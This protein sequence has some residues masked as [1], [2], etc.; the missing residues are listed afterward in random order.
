MGKMD[1]LFLTTILILCLPFVF[2]TDV[3]HGGETWT[4]HFDY[5]DQLRVNVT[6]TLNIDD[7]E[8]IMPDNCAENQT[9]YY[10]CECSNNYDFNVSFKINAVN[11]YTFDF[12]YDYYKEEPTITITPSGGGSGGSSG[13]SSW[14]CGEWTECI[15][16]KTIRACWKG[17]N[18]K[19]NYTQSK[20]CV[21]ETKEQEEKEESR[22]TEM[23]VKDETEIIENITAVI[24]QNE[25]EVI[26]PTEKE[27]GWT[28]F[29][30]IIITIAF[31]AFGFY[32]IKYKR[33]SNLNP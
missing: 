32:V 23:E 31:I 12:N 18:K 2:A 25:T 17:T 14:I 1:K 10:I 21:S 30:I 6:G 8:Y 16:S 7:G 33:N 5:C 28:Y 15:D 3:L 4:Y 11:E 29:G 22:V 19:I 26:L 20:K 24:V 13:T 9:N 27:E